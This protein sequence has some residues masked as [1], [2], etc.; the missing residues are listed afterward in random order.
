MP[1]KKDTELAKIKEH[2][3]D[4]TEIY[5]ITNT[6]NGRQYVGKAQLVSPK[7]IWKGTTKRWRAHVSEALNDKPTCTY[8]NNAIRKYTP[9]AFVY[10]PVLTCLVKNEGDF[11]KMFIDI[12]DTMAP[13]GYN[14]RY[15]GKH[16]KASEETRRKMSEALSGEKHPQYG[17][18]LTAEHR[19]KISKTNIDKA[20]RVDKDKSVL[21]KYM[22]YINW[23]DCEGYEIVSHPALKWLDPKKPNVISKKFVNAKLDRC[24][25]PPRTLEDN[26][27]RA[28]K[29]LAKLNKMVEE[30]NADVSVANS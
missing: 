18:P 10:E 14:L 8:L 23:K 20:V 24:E 9:E 27:E 17:K 29:F 19:A 1:R 6:I 16:G 11:E 13:K 12:Y 30:R 7:G 2:R 15:G 4:F 25:K 21:P 5:V 3:S 28:L 26:K 22:K